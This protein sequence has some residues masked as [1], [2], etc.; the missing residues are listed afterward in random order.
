MA[1]VFSQNYTSQKVNLLKQV[2]LILFDLQ[3]QANSDH[4]P[5]NKKFPFNSIWTR[6]R[7]FTMYCWDYWI[8]KLGNSASY[9]QPLFS[10]T[11][12]NH[13]GCPVVQEITWRPFIIIRVGMHPWSC[14]VSWLKLPIAWSL[15]SYVC[16][17]FNMLYFT[18]LS[19]LSMMK[20][21]L[22]VHN[23]FKMYPPWW[24]MI[25]ACRIKMCGQNIGGI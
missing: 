5:L 8:I 20:L 19:W 17:L 7:M 14:T 21:G 2:K 16:T 1:F 23:M 11:E 22:G 15:V 25:S 10:S 18:C 4:W 3:I 13:Y 6:V 12:E 24:F 9:A